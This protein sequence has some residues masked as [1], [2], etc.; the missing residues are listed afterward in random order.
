MSTFFKDLDEKS[1]AQMLWDMNTNPLYEKK[2]AMWKKPLEKKKLRRARR[3]LREA[4]K[5]PIAE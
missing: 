2:Q 1:R 5:E 4:E 3:E